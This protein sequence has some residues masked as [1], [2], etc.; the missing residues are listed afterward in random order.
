MYNS[1][2]NSRGF[3]LLE[4]L[5]TFIMTSILAVVLMQVVNG[6][7]GRSYWPLQVFDQR[8]ALQEAMEDIS[9][10]YRRLLMTDAT[11]LVSLQNN[12]NSGS[13]WPNT[14]P[15]QVDACYCLDL[16]ENA[17]DDWGETNPHN[18]CTHPAD[19]ILKVTISHNNQSLTTLF[20][21]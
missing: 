1:V 8:L 10:D 13:Y 19:T 14:T 15:I 11:P 4:I 12:I 21:R 6:H 9:A 16:V 3:T 5:L 2:F 17:Q 18:A 20:T 7:T